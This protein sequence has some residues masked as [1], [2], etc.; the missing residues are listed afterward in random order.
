MSPAAPLHPVRIRLSFGEG[1]GARGP[2]R[3]EF[4]DPSPGCFSGSGEPLSAP[5]EAAPQTEVAISA[6]GAPESDMTV[7]EIIL[8]PAG[9]GGDTRW[10]DGAAAW[11]GAAG[12]AR[13]VSVR[14][15]DVQVSWRPGRAVILAPQ[16]HAEA[17]LEAV[18]DFAHF[19]RELAAI[20]RDIAAA[21]SDV[22]ADAPAAYKVSESDRKND[23]EIGR[24]AL[25]VLR[26]RM[27]YARIEPHLSGVPARFGRAASAL[28]A[29]LRETTR[30]VERAETADG[31]IEVQE[32]VY[33]MAAQRL[34][35]DRHARAGF[36]LEAIIVALLAAETLLLFF[37]R[38]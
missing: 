3:F 13:T 27:R 33:E 30:C 35:E 23:R 1:A 16:A 2:L 8:L 7:L 31:Q 10:Q 24:R 34:G 25:E 14:A 19:E 29:A 9:L 20:E 5:P 15:A 28:G 22:H 32:Y 18:V 4:S 26:L 6:A 36:V 21:W 11:I 37:R 38:G 12:G 17:A